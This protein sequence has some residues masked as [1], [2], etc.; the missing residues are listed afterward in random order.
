MYVELY[1]LNSAVSLHVKY[2]NP[3]AFVVIFWFFINIELSDVYLHVMYRL[4]LYKTCWVICMLSYIC[5][6]IGFLLTCKRYE[7]NQICLGCWVIGNVDLSACWVI[8]IWL[9]I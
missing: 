9:Y 7:S 2:T 3:T 5:W 6:V 1:L 4:G 8:E